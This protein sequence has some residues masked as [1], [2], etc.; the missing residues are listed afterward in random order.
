LEI[1][2]IGGTGDLGS[3]LAVHLARHYKVV[4]GSRQKS[5]AESA[6]SQILSDKGER[7][8]LKENLEAGENRA[9][10]ARCDFLI[11]TVPH[12]TVL[13]SI[14]QLA[15]F[16]RGN[17]V[18]VSAAAVVVKSDDEFHSD[19]GGSS[20][21]QQIQHLLPES[22]NVATAF[23]TVPANILYKEKPISAD[24]LVACDNK[25]TYPKVAEVVSSISGLR[26]LYA[27]SLKQSGPIEGLTAMLLNVAINNRLK[28]PTLKLN[29]F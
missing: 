20:I 23:Q 27:G 28:S 5:K 19:L 4:I 6:I 16:F 13:E 17:Q 26:P 10:V 7:D 2:I 1:G 22:I 8:Y 21:T 11:E 15:P 24:V 12:S 9:A 3:A 25:E 14:R 29:S 18:L